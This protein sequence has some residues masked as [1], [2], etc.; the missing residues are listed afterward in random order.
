[1]HIPLS[2]TE[3]QGERKEGTGKKRRRNENGR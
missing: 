3:E 2:R 1:M